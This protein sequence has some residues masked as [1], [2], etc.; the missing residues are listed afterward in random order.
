MVE[1]R[2]KH[3][4]KSWNLKQINKQK[5]KYTLKKTR[6]NCGGKEDSDGNEY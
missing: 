5:M 6:V 3:F 1:K 2:E 4:Q